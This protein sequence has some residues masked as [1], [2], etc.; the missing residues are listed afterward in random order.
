M[1]FKI[2][3]TPVVDEG[4]VS[5][6]DA[7]RLLGIPRDSLKRIYSDASKATRTKDGKQVLRSKGILREGVHWRRG[8]DI[9]SPYSWNIPACIEALRAA[10]HTFTDTTTAGT[11]ALTEGEG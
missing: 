1:S 7:E 9:N 3:N 10:G 4:W 2:A 11:P 5:T 6:P 8:T